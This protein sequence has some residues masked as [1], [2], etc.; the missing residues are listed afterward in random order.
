V[1][2][3][4]AKTWISVPG[5]IWAM[6]QLS[7]KVQEWK[8]SHPKSRRWLWIFAVISIVAGIAFGVRLTQSSRVGDGEGRLTVVKNEGGTIAEVIFKRLK[9]YGSPA[10]NTETVFFDNN[11]GK[12]GKLSVEDSEIN[13]LSD[14]PVPPPDHP[15][16]ASSLSYKTRVSQLAE[17]T[18][19]WYEENMPKGP[20]ATSD[21]YHPY[22]T[23]K[24]PEFHDSLGKQALVLMQEMTKCPYPEVKRIYGREK[25]GVTL[26]QMLVLQVQDLRALKDLLPDQDSQLPCVQ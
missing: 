1:I 9:I 10:P 21:A 5:S 15:A 8:K 16:I 18:A 25:P 4:D 14:S 26:P 3:L 6:V 13:T 22:W 23:Q 24:M 17:A 12:I 11:G 2:D 19:K 7:A 20:S